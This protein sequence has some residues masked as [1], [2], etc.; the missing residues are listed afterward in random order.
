MEGIIA[1]VLV[2]FGMLLGPALALFIINCWM[3]DQ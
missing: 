2:V 1:T 3:D